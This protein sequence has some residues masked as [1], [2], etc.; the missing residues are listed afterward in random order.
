MNYKDLSSF[1]L[2]VGLGL[3]MLEAGW[4]KITASPAFSSAGYLKSAT[5]PFANFFQSLA[6][7]TMVDFLVMWGLTLGGLALILG[8]ANRIAAVG[9]AVMMVLFYFS[10]FPPTAPNWYVDDHIIY[11]LILAVLVTFKAGHVWG[12]G[13]TVEKIN[14]W[15]V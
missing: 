4:V 6:G 11:V 10:H 1:L 3:L 5:G 2:R 7:N 14:Q 13:K 9:L 12:L 15:L 8:V